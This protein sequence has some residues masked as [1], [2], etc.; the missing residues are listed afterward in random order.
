MTQSL[1][2]LVE[3]MSNIPTSGF[4]HHVDVANSS[5]EVKELGNAYNYMLDERTI[6]WID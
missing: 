1:R 3:Q 4:D 6:M 2:V 5:Y